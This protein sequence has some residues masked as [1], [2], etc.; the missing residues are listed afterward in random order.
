[1]FRHS[2]TSIDTNSKNKKKSLHRRLNKGMIKS[3][4]K[5][6]RNIKIEPL[7]CVFQ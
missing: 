5:K 4:P 6:V 1:M 2:E 3:G 7:E